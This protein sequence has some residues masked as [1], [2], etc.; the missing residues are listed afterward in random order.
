MAAYKRAVG[1]PYL[2][3][4]SLRARDEGCVMI[5]Q[6]SR[7]GVGVIDCVTIVLIFAL[8]WW[9]RRYSHDTVA[10][11]ACTFGS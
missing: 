9:A 1:L 5:N 10:K 4:G 2:I 7:T 11:C 8:K 6:A 3:A